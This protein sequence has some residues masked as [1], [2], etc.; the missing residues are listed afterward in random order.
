VRVSDKGLDK[1]EKKLR[2]W[3][4]LSTTKNPRAQNRNSFRI[5]CEKYFLVNQMSGWLHHQLKTKSK[6]LTA[7]AKL[8]VLPA[9]D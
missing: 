2:S 1:T 4:K 5:Y 7:E 8:H 6:D 3:E 9:L